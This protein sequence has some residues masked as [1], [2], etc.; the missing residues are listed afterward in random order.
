MIQCVSGVFIHLSGWCS[1]LSNTKY[2]IVGLLFSLSPRWDRQ[3]LV[4]CGCSNLGAKME[5]LWNSFSSRD[6]VTSVTLWVNL[7]PKCLVFHYW[8]DQ[9]AAR[10][11]PIGQHVSGCFKVH[12]TVTPA[13]QRCIYSAL[14]AL[15]QLWMCAVC[16]VMD[17]AFQLKVRNW[18]GW[19]SSSH[20]GD[21]V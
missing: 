4:L 1:W 12:I 17:G 9:T 16:V 5:T 6:M 19:F 2:S 10:C 21:G 8:C 13:A 18:N 7:P 14:Y 15:M 11:P 3:Y 20:R